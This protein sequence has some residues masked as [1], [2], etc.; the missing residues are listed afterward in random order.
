MREQLGL[1]GGLHLLKVLT[2]DVAKYVAELESSAIS[3]HGTLRTRDRYSCD[4]DGIMALQYLLDIRMRHAA[5]G[6]A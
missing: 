1:L 2:A 4:K 6:L 5:P 3:V